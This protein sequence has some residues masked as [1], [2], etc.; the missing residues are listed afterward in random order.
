MAVHPFLPPQK[1]LSRKVD[2]QNRSMSL[3]PRRQSRRRLR[4]SLDGI[5]SGAKLASFTNIPQDL[6]RVELSSPLRLDLKLL[7]FLIF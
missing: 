6:V 1:L 5:F 2:P 3:N 7:F 4:K